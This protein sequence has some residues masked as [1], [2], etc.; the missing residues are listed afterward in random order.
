MIAAKHIQTPAGKA[1]LVDGARMDTVGM[2]PGERTSSGI[3]PDDRSTE[4][5]RV[6]STGR[7]HDL[8][9]AAGWP[10]DP[11]LTL[12]RPGPSGDAN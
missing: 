5:R 7:E 3:A 6:E 9:T 8:V 10:A 11:V 1:P 4:V 12:P 2:T